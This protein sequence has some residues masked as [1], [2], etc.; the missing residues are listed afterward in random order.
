MTRRS[1]T[2]GVRF[3]LTEDDLMGKNRAPTRHQPPR[4]AKKRKLTHLVLP[5]DPAP[6]RDHFGAANTWGKKQLDWLNVDFPLE[7]RRDL[8]QLVLKVKDSDFPPQVR[9]CTIST[10]RGL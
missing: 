9:E 5:T 2:P 1:D 7:T 3:L 8:N 10:I 6:E 4:E